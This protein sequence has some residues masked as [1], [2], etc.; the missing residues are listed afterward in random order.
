MTPRTITEY[1]SGG[2]GKDGRVLRRQWTISR[3]SVFMSW[4]IHEGHIKGP[5]PVLAQLHHPIK[6]RRLPRPYTEEQLKNIWRILQKRGDALSRLAVAIGEETGLRIL[7][8]ANIRLPD[9]DRKAHRIF[10]RLPNKTM[11]E[12]WVPYH[13]KTRRYLE[14]WLKERDSSCTHDFLFHNIRGGPMTHTSLWRHLRVIFDGYITKL[15]KTYDEVF[16]GFKYHR[17]RHST[18][19]RLA[20]YGIDAATLMAVDGWRSWDTMYGY[21]KI[22][23]E[24]V[25]VSYQDARKEI[26][27]ASREESNPRVLS[28]EEFGQK[29]AEDA[30][31]PVS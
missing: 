12:R 5:N 3:I 29:K 7:E 30:G 27:K 6:E 19:S 20:N 22:Q 21:V 1:L 10:V 25:Q 28:L 11:Q 9:V 23:P 14:D 13:E 4:L 26:R 17:L 2:N 15:R 18:A 24:T 31:S 8:T 16:V